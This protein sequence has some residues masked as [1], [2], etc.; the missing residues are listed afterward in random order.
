TRFAGDLAIELGVTAL[1]DDVK[2]LERMTKVGTTLRD[3]HGADVLIMGCTG[4]ARFQ[5]ELSQRLGVP[6]IEPT[7]AG[8][9]FA[10]GA[11]QFG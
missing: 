7:R 1:N 5:R 4:M 9:M 8:T 2:V 10:V 6:V 11:V 3:Q